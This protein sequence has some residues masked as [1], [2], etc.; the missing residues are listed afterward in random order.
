MARVYRVFFTRAG[1]Q[2]TAKVSLDK[3]HSTFLP[4]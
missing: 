4:A 2:T 3:T 1:I